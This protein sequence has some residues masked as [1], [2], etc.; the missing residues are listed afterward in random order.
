MRIKL[1]FGVEL[2]WLLREQQCSLNAPSGLKRML[3]PLAKT[4]DIH[5]LSP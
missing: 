2:R 5:L 4:F 1:S 3:V